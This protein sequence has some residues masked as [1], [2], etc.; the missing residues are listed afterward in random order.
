MAQGSFYPNGSTTY[1]TV[2]DPTVTT[3]DPNPP[4]NAPSSFY[5]NEGG[6]YAGIELADSSVAD[7]EANALAASTSEAFAREDANRA[8]AWSFVAQRTKGALASL[9]SY[10]L[11]ASSSAAQASMWAR[12]AKAEAQAVAASLTARLAGFVAS[13]AQYTK[14]SRAAAA[15]AQSAVMA[16]VAQAQS[17]AS[18]ARREARN[19]AFAAQS[20]VAAMVSSAASYAK[21]AQGYAGQSVLTMNM[22]KGAASEAWGYHKRALLQAKAAATS[23]TAAAASAASLTD[24]QISMKAQVFN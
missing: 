13:A 20:A 15:Q 7:V 24:D 9:A 12:K 5:K 22:A 4:V 8:A 17:Y 10:A 1:T 3:P 2:N 14:Q 6:V 19:A 18:K 21:R 16:G 11:Q 23:A